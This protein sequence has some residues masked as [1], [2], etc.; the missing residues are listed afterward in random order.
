MSSVLMNDGANVLELGVPS[1][2]VPR[3]WPLPFRADTGGA[4][5]AGNRLWDCDRLWAGGEGAPDTRDGEG[6]RTD[7]GL[8]S[9]LEPVECEAFLANGLLRTD[10]VR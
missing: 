6:E 2:D 1:L 10:M 8:P 4:N 9:P 5:A 3:A 7:F